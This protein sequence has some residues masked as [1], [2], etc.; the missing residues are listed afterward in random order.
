VYSLF[1]ICT[2]APGKKEVQRMRQ[3]ILA[4]LPKE[5]RE[6]EELK[7]ARGETKGGMVRGF[8]YI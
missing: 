2:A 3:S 1:G 6:G 7:E 8:I 5:H 4:L